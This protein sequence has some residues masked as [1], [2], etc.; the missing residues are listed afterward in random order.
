MEAVNRLPLGSP[1]EDVTD[2]LFKEVDWP[3]VTAAYDAAT[4]GP[5][6]R[7]LGPCVRSTLETESS[8]TIEHAAN[9]RVIL[10]DGVSGSLSDCGC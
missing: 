9:P 7:V 5:P 6:E 4:A 10:L 1:A 3:R 8:E 2:V